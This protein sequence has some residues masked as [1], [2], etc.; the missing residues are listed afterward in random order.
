MAYVF[1]FL[2]VF[3]ARIRTFTKQIRIRIGQDKRNKEKDN[4]EKDNKEKESSGI[5]PR[6]CK[7]PLKHFSIRKLKKIKPGKDIYKGE[8]K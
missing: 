7:E 1:R 8:K 3:T 4:K 5:L 6:L 2:P